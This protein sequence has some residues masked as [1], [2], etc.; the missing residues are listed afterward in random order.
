MVELPWT[1]RRCLKWKLSTITPIVVRKTVVNSGFRVIKEPKDWI[2]T[3]GKHMKSPLF[4]AILEHQKVRDILPFHLTRRRVHIF[5]VFTSVNHF[6]DTFQIGRKDRL[7]RNMQ[8]MVAKFGNDEC[9]SHGLI[10][11]CSIYQSRSLLDL[12]FFPKRLFYLT[13]CV[14]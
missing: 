3:W 5:L 7:W 4:T 11:M 12:D 9:V 1:I 8:K 13:T 10:R 2:G 6:P 14:Y